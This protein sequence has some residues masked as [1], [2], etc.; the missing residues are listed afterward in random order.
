[1]GERKRKKK[2]DKDRTGQGRQRIAFRGADDAAGYFWVV[3]QMEWGL[4]GAAADDSIDK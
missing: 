3:G 1:M 2:R 4:G